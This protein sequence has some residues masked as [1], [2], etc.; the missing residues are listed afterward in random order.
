M[1][2]EWVDKG[3][4][5][6]L[7]AGNIISC[8]LDNYSVLLTND[9]DFHLTDEL[10]AVQPH[11]RRDGERADVSGLAA[12]VLSLRAKLRP[13]DYVRYQQQFSQGNSD[14]TAERLTTSNS[15]IAGLSERVAAMKATGLLPIPTSAKVVEIENQES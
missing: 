6:G 3:K 8:I 2:A 12:C 9:F 5:M 1:V 11:E 4:A 13:L 14:Y 7:P 15:A 10:I